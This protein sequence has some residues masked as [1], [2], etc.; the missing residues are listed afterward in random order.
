MPKLRKNAKQNVD[1]TRNYAT[2][3]YPESAAE[4]WKEMLED[5]HV[6]C[7]ISPYHTR[8]KNPDG[9]PKKPHYHVMLMFD[10]V[11][12]ID[13][14][15]K[16][17]QPLGGVG[18]E[19]LNSSRGYARYLCHLDNPEKQWYDPLDIQELSGANYYEVTNLASDRRATG[20]EIRNFCKKYKILSFSSLIEYADEYREDWL[21]YL[22]TSGWLVKEYLKSKAWSQQN[23]LDVDVAK[24]KKMVEADKSADN[25]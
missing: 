10:S 3:I 15:K 24:I 20:R 21:M 23:G 16:I 18:C 5:L 17:V 9:T 6:P 4:N 11:K 12:S 8:D 1:R 19:V 14:V 25:E 13:Q 2:I 7:F 22:E